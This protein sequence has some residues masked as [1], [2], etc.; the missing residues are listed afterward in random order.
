LVLCMEYKNN[1]KYKVELDLKLESE[2]KADLKI[3]S[4]H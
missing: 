2:M 3:P 1:T 4:S